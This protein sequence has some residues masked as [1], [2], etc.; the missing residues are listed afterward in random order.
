MGIAFMGRCMGMVLI[1]KATGESKK[2]M[3]RMQ[4]NK[5]VSVLA[6]A[7]RFPQ[8]YS[9]ISFQCQI[10]MSNHKTRNY[11]SET[12]GW[13]TSEMPALVGMY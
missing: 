3:F 8:V 7:S 6:Q 10:N 12:L 5:C 1:K 4:L 11:G 2:R 13:S 9:G